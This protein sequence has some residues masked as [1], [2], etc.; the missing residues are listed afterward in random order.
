MKRTNKHYFRDILEYAKTSLEFIQNVSYE[1]FITD[2][3]ATFATI[4]ALEVIGES[5]NRISDELKEKYPHL[6]W[7]EMRG[8]RNRIIHNYDDID[9][10]IIWNV[11][12]NEIPNLIKQIEEIIEEIE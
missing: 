11:L 1:E 4:R 9:Y 7:I 2:K 5:S 3:K 8:L 6:P 10:T 12:K